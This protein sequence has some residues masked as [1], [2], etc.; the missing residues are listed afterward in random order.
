MTQA[1][2][3]DNT[4]TL[5]S[6]YFMATAMQ[7]HVCPLCSRNAVIHQSSYPRAICRDCSHKACDAQGRSLQFIQH[8]NGS[9]SA[10][11]METGED[12]L[13]H[14]CYIEEA[15]CWADATQL[16]SIIIQPHDGNPFKPIPRSQPDAAQD[17]DPRPGLRSE[18]IA[19][20]SPSSPSEKP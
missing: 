18:P 19:A 16:G 1:K 7:T 2:V 11:V 5:E 12:H 4:S 13:S 8:D 17:S 15:I 10:Q 3:S 9:F 14:V 20:W 6:L